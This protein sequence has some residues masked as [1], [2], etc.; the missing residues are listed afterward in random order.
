VVV[1][2]C[3][4]LPHEECPQ[5]VLDAIQSFWRLNQEA[6]E[7]LA[8]NALSSVIVQFARPR[9]TLEQRYAQDV[10]D[11]AA[12]CIRQGSKVER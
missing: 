11:F 1:P 9:A 6:D 7:T 10:L 3:G 12:L 8:A 5:A 4:H 2:A